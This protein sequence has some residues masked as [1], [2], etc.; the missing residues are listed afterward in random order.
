MDGG[1][2]P[3]PGEKCGA[4][5]SC[6]TGK[7]Y[8]QCT[9][10]GNPCSSRFITSDGQAFNCASC[11]DCQSAAAMVG[12]WCGGGSTGGG[13]GNDSACA[14]KSTTN[15]CVDCCTTNHSSG[16]DV[17]NQ[18]LADCECNNPGECQFYCDTSLCVGSQPD[19]LCNSCLAQS[20]TCDSLPECDADTDCSALLACANA[21]P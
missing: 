12:T 14:A 16:Y 9:V 10:S 18:A 7:T 1:V 4:T 8:Q 17:F 15:E 6:G 2:K 20:T 21:C 13:G 3:L 11:S 19:S 5:A